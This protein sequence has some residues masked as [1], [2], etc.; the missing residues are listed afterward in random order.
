MTPYLRP[1]TLDIAL[2]ALAAESRTIIAGGTDFYPARAG[3]PVDEQLLDITGIEELRGIRDAGDHWRLGAAVTWT[4]LLETPLP[5]AFDALKLAA[6]E[7]GGRQIQNAGTLCGN[8]CNA[9]PA[10]DGMPALLAL[11]ALVELRSPSSTRALPLATF[12]SGPRRTRRLPDEIVTALLVPAPAPGALGGF[13]KLGARR[14]LVI[15]IVMAAAVL[16]PDDAGRIT[17]A[18]VA[19]GACS[20][21]A[22]RLP[23]LEADLAGHPV[24]A[25]LGDL[26]APRHFE[27]LAPIDDV[28]ASSAYRR[29][30]AHTVVA[31]LLS[32]LGAGR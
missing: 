11:N 14:Y 17:T 25:D 15:S 10:A 7:V 20:P 29:D 23:G 22:A 12:V 3:R 2:A 18:R 6:R 27:H 24:S 30:A 31:R 19:V 32:R 13:A 21:V 1:P 8:V 4:E 9:S 16:E 26:V 28:R 5:P